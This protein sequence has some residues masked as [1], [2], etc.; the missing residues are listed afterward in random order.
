MAAQSPV[1]RLGTADDVAAAIAFFL[2]P[3]AGVITGQVLYVCGGTSIGQ[4]PV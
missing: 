2:S 3:D 4:A 1:G